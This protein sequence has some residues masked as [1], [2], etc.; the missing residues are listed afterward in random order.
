MA[1]M[2]GSFKKIIGAMGKRSKSSSIM[3]AAEP[4]SADPEA[5][6]GRRRRM[7]GSLSGGVSRK[8]GG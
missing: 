3:P 8:L 6:Q 4:V 1:A 5:K 2:T 7:T